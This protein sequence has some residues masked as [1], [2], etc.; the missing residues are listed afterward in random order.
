VRTPVF[1][2]TE[3]FKRGMGE[4]T[5]IVEKE[6]DSFENRKNRDL[7]LRPKGTAGMVRAFVENKVYAEP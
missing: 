6:M 5:D 7:T 2:H 4:T 3:L 1:E